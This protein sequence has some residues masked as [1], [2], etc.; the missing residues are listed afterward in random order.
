[1]SENNRVPRRYGFLIAALC[2]AAALFCLAFPIYVVRPFR[3]QGAR[4]L[5]VALR[6]M[7]WRGTATVLCALAAVLAAALSWQALRPRGRVAVASLAILTVAVA[8]LSRINVYE[9]MFHPLGEPA[10]LPIEKVQLAPD[11]KVL[12]VKVNGT[13]RAYPIRNIAYHH[14]LN[15]APGGV[16]IVATY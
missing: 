11:E 2:F 8:A 5:A 3:Y 15:D 10:F 6:V 4:E 1:M 16:P 13:A 7:H 9:R 12:S 14:I